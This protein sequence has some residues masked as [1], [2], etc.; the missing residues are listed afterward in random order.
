M[1]AADTPRL[2]NAARAANRN[3]TVAMLP[4]DDHLFLKLDPNKT[5]T[6]AE[7][8]TPSYLDPA[9]FAAIEAWLKSLAP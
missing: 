2:V 4:D 9:L 1:L 6:G 8:F 5:S 7:Y 3:V